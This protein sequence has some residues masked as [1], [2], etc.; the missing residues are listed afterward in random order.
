MIMISKRID[1]EPGND[2]YGALASYIADAAHKG[3][4]V[5]T[6]WCMGCFGDDDYQRAIAGVKD[7]QAQNTRTTQAKT[8]HLVISFRPEDEDKLTLELFRIMEERFAAALGLSEHQ[9]HCGV[10]QNTSNLHMHL[11]YNLIHPERL[12]IHQPFRDF[13]V[14]DKVCRELEREYGLI[15]DN[16]LERATPKQERLREKASLVEAHT[17]QQS[18]EGYARG[19]SREIL[20]ALDATTSWQD[21]HNALGNHGLEIRPHGNGLVIKDRHSECAA[22]VMKAS[23]L[24]RSLSLKKLEARFGPYEP[25]QGLKQVQEQSLYELT[26]LH[27]SPERG[28]LFEEYRQNIEERKGRLEAIKQQEAAALS[29]IRERWAAKRRELERMSIDKRNRRRLIQVARKHEAEE[30]VLRP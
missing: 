25:S 13:I 8:Y 24:D 30:L 29:T 2:N 6:H 5:L 7:I 11:A 20:Q 19:Q 27:R 17:G 14:R 4:K 15:I 12:T 22:H 9:R 10:H 1:I 26:P 3:E 16:G 18:F 23:A 28:K 21:V